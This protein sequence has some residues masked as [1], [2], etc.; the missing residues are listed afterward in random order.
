MFQLAAFDI[1]GFNRSTFG[2]RVEYLVGRVTTF[3]VSG[4]G[5]SISSVGTPR[6]RL[7]SVVSRVN[8]PGAPVVKR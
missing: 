8:V 5:Q 4:D 1:L 6:A 3:D 2:W 7:P